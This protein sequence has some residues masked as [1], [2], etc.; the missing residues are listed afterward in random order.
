MDQVQV[1]FAK[2]LMLDYRLVAPPKFTNDYV[3]SKHKVSELLRVQTKPVLVLIS[4]VEYATENTTINIFIVACSDEYV[5]IGEAYFT[6]F[7]I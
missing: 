5:P 1:M 3:E 4:R 2:L 6:E 7:G